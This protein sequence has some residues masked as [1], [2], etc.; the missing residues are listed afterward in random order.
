MAPQCLSKLLLDKVAPHGQSGRDLY[1]LYFES[2]AL[3]DA[4]SNLSCVT[5]RPRQLEKIANSM[6]KI[7]KPCVEP[8]FFSFNSFHDL[9]RL[10][11]LTKKEIVIFWTNTFWDPRV[12]VL[13]DFRF[14]SPEPHKETV[15]LLVTSDKKELHS[16]SAQK[17]KGLRVNTDYFASTTTKFDTNWSHTLTVSLGVPLADNCLL[18][19]L[20]QDL[21]QN[22]QDLF[23]LWK[24]PILFVCLG[25]TK[26]ASKT[27]ACVIK[28]PALSHFVTVALVGPPLSQMSGLDVESVQK[29]ACFV[30][31]S[32][33]AGGGGW[34]VCLLNPVFRQHVIQQLIKTSHKD[35]L[36]N[37]SILE[38]APVSRNEALTAAAVLKEKKKKYVTRAEQKGRKCVCEI[39]TDNSYSNNMSKVGPE[40]LITYQP[41]VTELLRLMGLDTGENIAAIEKL[42]DLS[43]A[44]MDIE[45][46]TLP[47]DL[48]PPVDRATGVDHSV[49]DGV[50]L[51]GHLQKIQKPLMIAHMDALMDEPKVFVVKSDQEDSIYD[52][53]K[54]YWSFVRERHDECWREKKNLVGPILE[55]LSEYKLKH[56]QFYAA[57]KSTSSSTPPST[58]KQSDND[59]DNEAVDIPNTWRQSVPGKL[60]AALRRLVS[61]YAVFS[62]YG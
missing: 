20:P 31:D 6:Y 59:D 56:T 28:K 27:N 1:Q 19:N 43:V 51:E 5:S 61:N 62:F 50:I 41:D 44:A 3:A 33:A 13:H 7:K 9:C 37:R 24:E 49:I 54:D 2:F 8:S 57:W 26:L 48:D 42:C 60:N 12:I 53:M 11:R 40:R 22:R 30:G 38:L 23:A 4:D 58:S 32:A 39:C 46:T 10:S 47:L 15:F 17:R 25:K 55:L 45:S 35:K 18:A 16:L 14:L 34:Q 21:Q 36:Q 52:M 29:V